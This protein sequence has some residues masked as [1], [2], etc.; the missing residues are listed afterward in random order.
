MV[1]NFFPSDF[2]PSLFIIGLFC[3]TPF[4]PSWSHENA[5]ATAVQILPSQLFNHNASWTRYPVLYHCNPDFILR[6]SSSREPQTWGEIFHTFSLFWL[7]S[8]G[9]CW[10][11]TNKCGTFS[12]LSS[13]PAPSSKNQTLFSLKL[14]DKYNSASWDSAESILLVL[15]TLFHFAQYCEPHSPSK[16]LSL[17]NNGDE[18]AIQ[19]L[20]GIR[21]YLSPRPLGPHDLTTALACRRIHKKPQINALSR[22]YH[23]LLLVRIIQVKHSTTSN[24]HMIKG[25]QKKILLK[26]SVP[27]IFSET[28]L[29]LVSWYCISISLS[30]SL[31]KRFHIQLL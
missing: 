25:R 16:N 26:L 21:W 3:L 7:W 2:C 12:S 22:D 8:V 14:S 11:H 27:G 1:L 15:F 29:R 19:R 20:M 6:R 28:H 9:H 24:S 30:L 5:F 4:L 17:F 18:A 31:A 10:R 13:A 23:L